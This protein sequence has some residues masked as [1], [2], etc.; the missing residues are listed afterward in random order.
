MEIFNFLIINKN[1]INL[2]MKTT[3]NCFIME[4]SNKIVKLIINKYR[5]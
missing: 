2:N 3:K 5:I 4:I 1:F